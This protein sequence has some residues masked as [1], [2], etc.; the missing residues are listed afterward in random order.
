[1]MKSKVSALGMVMLAGS[2]LIGSSAVA[3]EEEY[4]VKAY[5]PKNTIVWNTPVKATFDHAVHTRDNGF[6]CSA[7]HGE[8]FAMQRDVAV[9]SKKFNMAALNEGKFCGACHDGETAFASDTNCQACHAFPA[10][11][12]VWTE[13]VKAVTFSHKDHTEEFGL[14]CDSCHNSAFAMKSGAAVKSNNFTMDALYKGQ[15]CG[16][17]HDGD[18]AFASN[19]RC[20]TCHIGVK[21]YNRMMGHDPAKAAHGG[22]H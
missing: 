17:C 15:F 6:E 21:G 10:D 8:L 22:G 5:G 2:F 14:D 3:A 4:D 13:P 1:M 11:P 16:A 12:I 19:T 9:A 7:C 18:T 20:T